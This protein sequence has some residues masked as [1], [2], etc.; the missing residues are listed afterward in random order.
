MLGILR[1]FTILLA[2][3]A[4]QNVSLNVFLFFTVY[5]VSLKLNR[6]DLLKCYNIIILSILLLA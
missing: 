3:H 2:H 1:K 4:T 5:I 6:F